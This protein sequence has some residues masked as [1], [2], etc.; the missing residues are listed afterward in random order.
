ML[1]K[2]ISSKGI[3]VLG[4]DETHEITFDTGNLDVNVI[5]SYFYLNSD[6]SYIS[7]YFNDDMENFA[8]IN[9]PCLPLTLRDVP[10]KKITIK[11][12]GMTHN[13]NQEIEISYFGFY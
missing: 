9:N 8:M 2:V 3:I 12:S 10:V 4:V 11:N 7:L 5:L 13:I 6:A 1:G